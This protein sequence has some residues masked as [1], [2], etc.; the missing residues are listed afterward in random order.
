MKV[1]GGDGE[2]Y[3]PPVLGRVGV[4]DLQG[5][6]VGAAY[7]VIV[8]KAASRRLFVETIL[9]DV[10]VYVRGE[11]EEVVSGSDRRVSSSG[12]RSEY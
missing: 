1:E 12:G 10:Y 9:A 3:E 7:A 8:V 2:E 11:L 5:P 4:R 6:F